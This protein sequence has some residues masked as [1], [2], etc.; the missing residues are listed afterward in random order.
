MTC[1]QCGYTKWSVIVW[2]LALAFVIKAGAFSGGIW[3]EN[4]LLRSVVAWGGGCLAGVVFFGA[5]LCIIDAI[6][7]TPMA[8]NVAANRSPFAEVKVALF[9]L[10]GGLFSLLVSIGFGILGNSLD[11]DLL[12]SL[13]I[14]P[15][16]VGIIILVATIQAVALGAG[17]KRLAVRLLDEPAATPVEH[18]AEEGFFSFH[19]GLVATPPPAAC[20]GPIMVPPAGEARLR[21]R[22]TGGRSLVNSAVA[23]ILDG[24]WI[25]TG[26]ARKGFEVERVT[27]PGHH[28]LGLRW[29]FCT[30]TFLL[31][32]PGGGCYE[33]ELSWSWFW[34]KYDCREQEE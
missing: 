20:Q 18:V 16:A 22:C 24:E 14:V 23:V 21:I 10:G 31:D 28:E 34:G 19:P 3:L 12:T 8:R 11:W 13:G 9:D 25:A 27:T 29:G 2:S 33:A 5:L 15:C 32:I 6:F 26:S 7:T 30:Q 17:K 1:R 4:R